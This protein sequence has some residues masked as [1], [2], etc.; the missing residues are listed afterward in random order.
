MLIK[1]VLYLGSDPSR[2]FCSAEVKI[3][4]LPLFEV[5]PRDYTLPSL[6]C[7]LSDWH[8]YSHM[9]FTS[10]HAVSVL[11]EALTYHVLPPPKKESVVIAIGKSTAKVLEQRGWKVSFCAVEERQEGILSLLRSIEWKEE[12]YAFYPRSSLARKSL[13]VFLLEREIRHQVCDLYD[14]VAKSVDLWPDLEAFDEI[15][16]TSPSTVAIFFSKI[17]ALPKR[18]QLKAIGPITFEA[19]MSYSRLDKA[20]FAKFETCYYDRS[21]N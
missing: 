7:V 19:L 18:P 13:E 17:T 5:V 4:H 14:T 15:F 9:I 1:H 10:K 16:F 2:F 12:S 20:H 3:T 6:L 8:D 21:A 11:V